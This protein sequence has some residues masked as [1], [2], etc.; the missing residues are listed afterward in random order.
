[1]IQSVLT[2]LLFVESSS[3][4]MSYSRSSIE[5][6]GL[7]QTK[8]A[9][10]CYERRPGMEIDAVIRRIEATHSILENDSMHHV[11][12]GYR[13]KKLDNAVI[14]VHY[15][16]SQGAYV[17]SSWSVREKRRGDIAIPFLE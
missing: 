11:T 10:L 6:K 1:M 9:W 12:M 13:S 7:S 16:R 2:F 8:R 3:V 14:V 5:I 15:T 4:L 17:L